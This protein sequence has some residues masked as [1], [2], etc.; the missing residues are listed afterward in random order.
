MMEKSQTHS[1]SS[2][3]SP[4]ETTEFG[5]GGISSFEVVNISVLKCP[6]NK[7]IKSLEYKMKID[8]ETCDWRETVSSIHNIH[9]TKYH[10][11]FLGNKWDNKQDEAS[12]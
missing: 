12:K 10:K 2:E 7:S 6:A 9:E 4:P 8:V 1:K 11:V 3:L 5:V